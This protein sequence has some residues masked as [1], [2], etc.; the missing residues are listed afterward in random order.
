MLFLGYK[1]EIEVLENKGSLNSWLWGKLK[2]AG[3]GLIAEY[4]SAM[5]LERIEGTDFRGHGLKV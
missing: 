2:A 1:A 3:A 5:R 4:D